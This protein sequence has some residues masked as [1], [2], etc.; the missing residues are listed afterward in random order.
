VRSSELLV[1]IPFVRVFL[2]RKLKESA[3][4]NLL[5]AAVIEGVFLLGLY[6][7]LMPVL[8]MP[9]YNAVIFHPTPE[10]RRVESF[11]KELEHGFH[12]SFE[13]TRFLAPN[14]S[15]LHGWYF[16]LPHARKTILVN[17]GNAGNIENRLLLCPLF[18]KLGCSVFL[19]DYE[20]YGQSLGRP[21]LT[22]VCQDALAAFDYLVMQKNVK[23]KDVVV[24]GESIGAG[25]TSELSTQRKTGGLILQSP[26][27]SLPECARDKVPLMRLYPDCAFPQPRLDNLQILKKQHAP[28]LIIHGMKD[29]ILPY[30]Y[31][32]QIMQLASDPKRLVLLPNAGHNDVC[33]TDLKITFRALDTFVSALSAH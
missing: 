24:Y 14:G 28:L 6:L 13:D 16:L 18:L 33:S 9:I 15:K 31:S 3:Q 17:H 25:I 26:F 30:T 29:E 20:G 2:S 8:A 5:L 1:H 32:Q 23:P 21:T 12:C 22:S 10:T 27:T 7:G 11:I 4:R 19:Y